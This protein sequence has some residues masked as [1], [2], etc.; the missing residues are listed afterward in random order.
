MTGF[1]R[2]FR[3]ATG[4]IPFPFQRTFAE[5]RSLPQMIDV[6][7][8]LGKTAM[9]VVGWLWRR[10]GDDEERLTS[11]PRRLVYCLPMRVLVEQT[12]D[13]AILW[14]QNLDL[15]GGKALFDN[16]DGKRTL[17]SYTPDWSEPDKVTVHVLMG[18]EDKDDW[19]LYPE[20][21][22]ILIGTQDM[23][24][25][26]AL[27]RGYAA[28]RARWPMQFG[29]LH[30]D[31]LWVLDEVQLMGTGLSTTA[32]LEGFRRLLPSEGS[33]QA[34]DAHGCRSVWMS[35]TMRKDWLRTVDFRQYVDDL[36]TLELS[37]EDLAQERV[38][39]RWEAKKPLEKAGAAM[40]DAGGIAAEIRKAHRPGTRTIVVVNTV[41]R[42]CELSKAL[43]VE[44]GGGTKRG[45]KGGKV[46]T[47]DAA[48][49]DGMELAPG[50][51][52]LHSRFRLGDRKKQIDKALRGIMPG[53]P[54]TIVVSTQVIEAGVD[55]SSTTLF[56]EPAPW[57]SLVQRFG[58]CN[59]RGEDA[60][61]RVY[62][63]D[64]PS[65]RTKA[66]KLTP[67][68]GP[69]SLEASRRQLIGL[70]DVGIESLPDV[71]LSFE[72]THVIRRKDLVDLF[73]TTPDLAG[74]DIDIDRFVREVDDSAVRV[75]WREWDQPKG[76]ESPP[77]EMP[78]PQRG[79]LCPAPVGEFRDFVKDLRRKGM[80][81]R[82]NFLDRKWERVVRDRIAAG[83]VYLVHF[84]A[85][86]YSPERGWGLDIR[87][88]VVPVDP[89]P[90]M[91]DTAPDAT[92]DDPLSRIGVWQ[93][94]AEHTGDVCSELDCIV[95]ALSLADFETEALIHAALWH[96]RGKAHDV[97]QNAIDDG[98]NV[99]CKGETVLR[100]ERPEQWQ[101]CRLIAKAPDKQKNAVGEV[102]DPGFWRRY[103]WVPGK[104]RK[105]FRHELASALA[106]L[107]SY[108]E[109]IP[110][111]HRDMIAYLV[112]AH[113]GKVRLS[114]R[115][116]PNES[117][118]GDGLRFARGV[119]DGDVLSAT[120]LGGGVT[121]PDVMLSLEP[122][123][124]GLCEKPPFAGQPSWAERMLRLRDE[125]GPFRLVYLEAILRAA[126]MR[127][128]RSAGKQDDQ[129]VMT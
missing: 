95:N 41:K 60:G 70:E 81:W 108:D 18:G 106:V 90:G 56:T 107:L 83:Q 69:V 101:G 77:E 125:L 78:A 120:D 100:K 98:Q 85:G 1:E 51:V 61:V 9:A 127:A 114:I 80:V 105:Y 14:L 3:K 88:R 124:L 52:L 99:Q 96:D 121:A 82:W 4:D 24:L 91:E 23:L 67:P 73:D 13:S 34:K 20:A 86:G 6:P 97:F 37:A 36:P 111:E 27:N 16:K 46:K 32:Q 65:D 45:R 10:F 72:H 102:T 104:G 58:R 74:S 116:L 2:F 112:A 89:S 129:G 126:D 8:G 54:G 53:E 49:G 30:T 7:T 35:A 22:A 87:T 48:Q 50:I 123:E 39:R 62:W 38:R 128:S 42:A 113:H 71:E 47:V 119:W 109:T 21:G 66:D 75:F 115:S 118:P 122:M 43:D 5:A 55:V 31:C 63:F 94:I 25:S 44:Y 15:L 59:R 76:Y 19:D 11:T 40:G 17:R 92:G 28:S 93:T 117:R 57:A 64:L 110:P 26:R 29:L 79:E 33:K 84:Y 12:R 103:D 68:Y